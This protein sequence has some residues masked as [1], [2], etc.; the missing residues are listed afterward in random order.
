MNSEGKRGWA[1]GGERFLSYSEGAN[2][3]PNE[4]QIISCKML[5]YRFTS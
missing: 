2:P 5:P 4:L 1:V 3:V